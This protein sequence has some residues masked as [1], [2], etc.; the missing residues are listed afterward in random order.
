MYKCVLLTHIIVNV[1]FAFFRNQFYE[2]K[3][4]RDWI[5]TLEKC[6]ELNKNGKKILY[7]MVK[8]KFSYFVT[9]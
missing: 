4:K 2:R 5:S 9:G 6:K 8:I 3:V 7:F 1:L